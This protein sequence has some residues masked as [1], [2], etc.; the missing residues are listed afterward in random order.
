M[1]FLDSLQTSNSS[2]PYDAAGNDGQVQS[3]D[4]TLDVLIDMSSGDS[5]SQNHIH[6]H[7]LSRLGSVWSDSELCWTG[8]GEVREC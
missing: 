8:D 7:S 1:A 6:S 3:A 5:L 2:K 4:G